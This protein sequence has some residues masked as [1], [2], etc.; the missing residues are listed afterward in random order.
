M[1][2]L[3]ID[4]YDSFTFNLVHLV[5]EVSTLRSDVVKNDEIDLS[6]AEEYSHIILSPGPGLPS[7][8]GMMREVLRIFGKSKRILGV[9]LGMQAIIECYGGK[10][11]NL[12]HV[13]HGIK[14]D[15]Q[16]TRQSS[17]LF[18]GVPSTFSVGRYH[19][20]VADVDSLPTCLEVTCIDNQGT[21]M[22]VEHKSHSVYGVQFHPESYMTEFG[23]ELMT[24]FLTKPLS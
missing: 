1:K 4:N 20:W 21:I 2:I 14:S 6:R 5:N 7:E 24:N 15:V 18:D 17:I 23:K 19:S 10:L 9:C 3:I 12:P 11:E 16:L 13:F 8:A 22:G